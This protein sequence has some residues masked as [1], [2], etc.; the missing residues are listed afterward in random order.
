MPMICRALST[1]LGNE[2]RV[3]FILPAVFLCYTA[4]QFNLLAT[5]YI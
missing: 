3:V 5:L 4:G 1:V 2:K